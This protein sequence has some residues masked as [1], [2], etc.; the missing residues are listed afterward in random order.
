MRILTIIFLVLTVGACSQNK[1][2]SK[3]LFVGNSYTYYEN[4]PQI[5]SII[6]DSSHTKLVT[7]KSVAGGAFLSDH[8]HGRH[9]LDTR[10]KIAEGNYDVVVL[11]EQSLAAIRRPD[12]LKKYVRLFSDLIRESGA[13]T[14]LYE[15]WARKTAPEQQTVI[16][17][18]YTSIGQEV[19]ATVVPVGRIWAKIQQQYPQWD[20]YDTDGSHPSRWGTFVAASVFANT[21]LGELPEHMEDEYVVLDHEG[22]QVRLLY[23]PPPQLQAAKDVITAD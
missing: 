12:S 13:Q 10:T 19:E 18:V 16:S 9:G 23:I 11:Q 2:R 20:L 21:L 1:A 8:W 3:V 22:E 15:T 6:S 7:K 14:Y 5:V 17:G 4:L